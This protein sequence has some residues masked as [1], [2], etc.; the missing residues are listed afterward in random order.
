VDDQASF[1]ASPAIGALIRTLRTEL[2]RVL[3]RKILEPGFEMS[4]DPVVSVVM[5]L[6][7]TD[8]F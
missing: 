1:T 7:A 6:L 4:R 5:Q 8:G 2:N 3:A